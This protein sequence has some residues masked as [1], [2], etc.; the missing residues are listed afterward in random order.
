MIGRAPPCSYLEASLCLAC[1]L[2]GLCCLP[3]ARSFFHPHNKHYKT[4]VQQPVGTMSH[5]LS[6]YQKQCLTFK[7][8]LKLPDKVI[9][10]IHLTRW[11][12]LNA[13]LHL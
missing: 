12:N 6:W 5:L 11:E 13:M 2:L 7:A 4:K 8:I 10:K 3:S 9:H 1:I